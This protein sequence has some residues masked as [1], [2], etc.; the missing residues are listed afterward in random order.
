MT[1]RR[2]EWLARAGLVIASI[3]AALIVLELGCR[4]LRGPDWLVH[5]PNLVLKE[6]IDTRAQ[7]VGRLIPDAQL[8]FVARPGFGK[9][10]LH[11]DDHGWRIAPNPEGVT[12]AE[13]PILVV[14]DSIAHGDE[15]ADGEAWPSRLQLLLRRRVLNGAMSGYGFDQIVLATEKAAAEVKPAAIILSFTA[16]DTRRNEMKRVWGAEKPYFELVNGKL[17]LRNSP[18]PPSPDPADTLDFWHRALG[19]SV[20]LD[21]VLRHKGWRYEWAVDH[22]RVLPRNEGEKLSCALLPR[23]KGLGVPLLVVAEYNRYVFENESYAAETRRTTGALLKCAADLGL[24]TFDLFDLDKDAVARRGLDT[25]FRLSHP[26][27]EGARLAADA[28]A[29]ELRKRQLLTK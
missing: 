11:Y 17:T 25:L 19:W 26:S 27:P 15:I 1:S 9:D 28:I 21:T 22:E 8:G 14:G 13:P 10:G 6:R 29:A 2:N 5:W 20:L 16:D 7:G 18:V 3:I 24:A 23:L 12:L 4:L